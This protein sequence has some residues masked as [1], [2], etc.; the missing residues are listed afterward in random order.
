MQERPKG[1]SERWKWTPEGGQGWGGGGGCGRDRDRGMQA[2]RSS[3]K[4]RSRRTESRVRKGGIPETR[5]RSPMKD[6]P[7]T[8]RPPAGLGMDDPD[9]MGSGVTLASPEASVVSGVPLH[10]Q[11]FVD[12]R[13]EAFLRNSRRSQKPLDSVRV[14]ADDARPAVRVRAAALRR[15]TSRPPLVARLR[16]VALRA[17]HDAQDFLSGASKG[18]FA[19]REFARRIRSQRGKAAA[20]QNKRSRI[21]VQVGFLRLD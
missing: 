9:P 15:S 17:R 13:R 21:P 11:P 12:K 10:H 7:T 6:K 14:A 20:A 5:P 8:R 16:R 3:S 18:E 4:P 19:R 2:R 1:G